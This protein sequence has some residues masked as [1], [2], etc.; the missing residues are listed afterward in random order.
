MFVSSDGVWV[1]EKYL[2][3]IVDNWFRR[4]IGQ[5]VQFDDF[6]R[7]VSL[8]IA[9]NAWG[10]YVFSKDK[11]REMVE[12]A[13]KDQ[14][15]IASFQNLVETD[16]SF[17]NHIKLLKA[18]CPVRRNRPYRG[19]DH[20]SI[21]QTNNFS[22]ALEVIYVVRCNLFHGEKVFE[23]PRDRALVFNAFGVLSKLFGEVRSNAGNSPAAQTILT[24]TQP[25]HTDT[26]Y[27]RGVGLNCTQFV[28]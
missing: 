27:S 15:L 17:L 23:D 22:E 26:C 14:R 2:N 9:F 11:D 13:K 19:H 21:N 6:D 16:L 3:R 24:A 25:R 8:W 10:T 4:A 28:P 20:A 7:F 1:T 12:A 18:E 5:D